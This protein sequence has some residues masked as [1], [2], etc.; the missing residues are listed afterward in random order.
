MKKGLPEALKL[1]YWWRCLALSC[2]PGSD[3]EGLDESAGV[4]WIR[5]VSKVTMDSVPQGAVAA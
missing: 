3:D 2:I 5:A 1:R 4:S